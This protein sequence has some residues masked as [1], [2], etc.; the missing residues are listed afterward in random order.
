M[1]CVTW[2]R[3]VGAWCVVSG[4]ALGLVGKAAAVASA[5]AQ[6]DPPLAGAA[7]LIGFIPKDV[8]YDLLDRLYAE[9]F[10]HRG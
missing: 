8:R 2:V 7:T 6:T 9:A 5:S 3:A 1:R 4:L 10:G